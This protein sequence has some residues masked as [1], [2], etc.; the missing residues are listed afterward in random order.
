M[1]PFEEHHLKIRLRPPTIEFNLRTI[2]AIV[3]RQLVLLIAKTKEYK[4]F[5]FIQLQVLYSVNAIIII[6]SCNGLRKQD[7]ECDRI[8]MSATI[9]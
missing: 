9:R 6:S 3:N 4:T 5:I 8:G 2:L 1:S 7:S